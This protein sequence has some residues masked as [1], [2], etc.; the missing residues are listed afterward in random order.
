MVNLEIKLK[1][2]RHY[3]ASYGEEGDYKYEKVEPDQTN[4]RF[5]EIPGYIFFAHHTDDEFYITE[6]LSGLRAGIGK[7]VDEAIA[8][9]REKLKD[10]ANLEYLSIN[11]EKHINK[12]GV[13]P[14]YK[15]FYKIKSKK[16]ATSN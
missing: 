16:L 11:I 2:Y 13:S 8:C 1:V 4:I 6:S 7:S 15:T 9:V 14:R 5:D 3:Y 10:E 12:Y